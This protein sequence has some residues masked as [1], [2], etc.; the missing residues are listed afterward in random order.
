MHETFWDLVRDRSHWEFELFLMFL[1]D[2]V[3]AGLWFFV[4]KFI[5]RR[6]EVTTQKLETPHGICEGCGG[7]VKHLIES[8]IKWCLGCGE[9]RTI[10]NSHTYH[11]TSD[12]QVSGN[13][14]HNP[15]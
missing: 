12:E 11:Y 3:I 5:A 6:R 7:T 15:N 8:G 2:G 1:F 10:P 13:R 14:D 9:I 4:V